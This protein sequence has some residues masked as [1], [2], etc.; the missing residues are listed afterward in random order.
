[1]VLISRTICACYLGILAIADVRKRSIPVWLLGTGAVLALTY[2]WIEQ[3]TPI[4]LWLAGAA[5]GGVFLIVG[6]VTREALGYGDGVLIGILG[7]Y[8]GIWE[9]FCL[10]TTAFFLTAFYAAVILMRR[11]FR[12]KTDFPFVPFLETAYMIVLA[13]GK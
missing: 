5:V 7:I 1:M 3:E 6:K 13:A 4:V 11:K 9:L 12:R 10:L 8:L 2:R